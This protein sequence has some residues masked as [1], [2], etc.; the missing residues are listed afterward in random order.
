M[1]TKHIIKQNGITLIELM[2]T[3]AILAT[4]AAIAIPAYKGY[5][6]TSYISECQ[7]EAAAIKL[8]EE[9]YFLE[10]GNYF[11][12]SNA[13]GL[14]S[15]SGS[16]YSPTSSGTANCEYSVDTSVAGSYTITAS[17]KAGGKL[18]DLGTV[19]TFTK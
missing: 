1:V 6:K 19:A 2:V 17:G 10:N 18:A 5:I 7:T 12:G 9:E 14:S 4:V 13:S 3:L 11:S 15:A 8:A 16:I